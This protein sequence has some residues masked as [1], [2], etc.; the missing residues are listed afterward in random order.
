MRSALTGVLFLLLGTAPAFAT[1]GKTVASVA[2]DRQQMGGALRTTAAA[3][4]SVQ[5]IERDDGIVVRE[6]VSPGG[7]VFGVAWSGPARPDLAVLLGDYFAAFQR[8]P[9]S[10]ARHRGGFVLRTDALV[11]ELGGQMRA[12][13]GRAYVPALVPAS[14]SASAVR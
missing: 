2:R 1:L 5:E 13:H 10:P 12:M 11:V 3:G 9:R 7:Q 4:F 14:V 8:A 6:Y